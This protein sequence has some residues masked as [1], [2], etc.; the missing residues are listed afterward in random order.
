MPKPTLID[1]QAA[2]LH[3]EETPDLTFQELGREMGV[4][5]QYCGQRAAREL[6]KKII[7][8]DEPDRSFAPPAKSPI[9]SPPAVTAPPPD[10][11]ASAPAAAQAQPADV[12]GRDKERDAVIARHRAQW[13]TIRL[14]HSSAIKTQKVLR[15]D[16]QGNQREVLEV[17]LLD[18]DKLKGAAMAARSLTAL[19]RGER[20]A[21]GLDDPDDPMQRGPVAVSVT[22]EDGRSAASRGAVAAPVTLPPRPAE[23]VEGKRE[24]EPEEPQEHTLQNGPVT[25]H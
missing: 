5:G 9:Q 23:L 1:W 21:W 6:W 19:Q 10:A 2:R 4:S 14:I 22:F 3:W 7:T 8:E 17:T 20:Q 25:E 16:A 15:L 12:A 18:A 24:A 13:G 11:A